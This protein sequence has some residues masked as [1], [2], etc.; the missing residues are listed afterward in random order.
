MLGIELLPSTIVTFVFFFP[1]KLTLTPLFI[2]IKILSI[3]VIWYYHS[4][5]E[6]SLPR[7]LLCLVSHN[8]FNLTISAKFSCPYSKH[9]VTFSSFS[10]HL[11]LF[12]Y[13]ILYTYTLLFIPANLHCKFQEKICVFFCYFS[14]FTVYI[15]Y[16]FDYE[17]PCMTWL[18]TG[19]C[20]TYFC[21]VSHNYVYSTVCPS[22]QKKKRKYS[23]YCACRN[24]IKLIWQW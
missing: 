3:Y 9:F 18:L 17:L 10:M 15:C 1:T 22:I 16:Y 4:W 20:A 2:D 14:S 6:F 13:Y 23:L 24:N 8:Y 19:L 21:H 7:E 12:I 11:L 5:L